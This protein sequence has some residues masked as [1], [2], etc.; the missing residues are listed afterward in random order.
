MRRFTV[1]SLV[2]AL[3]LAMAAPAGAKGPALSK[4]S[5]NDFQITILP[6]P[7]PT[8]TWA[9]T[10]SAKEMKD[11][12]DKGVFQ[13]TENDGTEVFSWAFVPGTLG[14]RETSAGDR[15]AWFNVVYEEL[16]GTELDDWQVE[17]LELWSCPE[18]LISGVSQLELFVVDGDYDSLQIRN[19]CSGLPTWTYQGDGNLQV[20]I[21]D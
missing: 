3:V 10:F 4:T 7:T 12:G 17:L 14:F 8:P 19:P 2:L 6:N 21:Y 5:T 11:G 16:P 15:F 20:K 13:W 1:A 9:V 18:K